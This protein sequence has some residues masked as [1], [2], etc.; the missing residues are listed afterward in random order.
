M[1]G[2]SVPGLGPSIGSAG[3]SLTLKTQPFPEQGESLVGMGVSLTPTVVLPPS[4]NTSGAA[5]NNPKNSALIVIL[6]GF[7]G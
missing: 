3:V 5:F 2:P 6:S 7:G 4:T 1:T